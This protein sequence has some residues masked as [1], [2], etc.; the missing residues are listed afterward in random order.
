MVDGVS[1]MGVLFLLGALA[2]CAPWALQVLR[3]DRRVPHY[4]AMWLCI[5]LVL[6]LIYQ[7]F[8]PF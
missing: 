7:L 3:S 8:G 1:W 5:A 2:V 6:G 4:I